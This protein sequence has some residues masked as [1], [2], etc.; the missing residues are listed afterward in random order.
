[1]RA[2]LPGLLILLCCLPGRAPG[3]EFGLGAYGSGI[4]HSLSGDLP[5]DDKWAGG[6]SLGAGLQLELHFTEDIALSFQ[7]G[8]TPRNCQRSFVYQGEVIDRTDYELDY[9]SFPLLVRVSSDP[10][11][12]RG[13]VTAGMNLGHLV[14]GRAKAG[15][16]TSQEI[17]TPL[18]D[19]TIGALFGAG[20]MFPVSDRNSIL[21]ELRYEQG[22][23]D[24]V[25][26]GAATPYSGFDSPSIKY[27][28]F[29]LQASWLF[30]TGGE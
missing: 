1:V 19:Y 5:K 26:R 18:N 6:G 21:V 20:A 17:Q 27:R 10:G 9:L 3:L 7:P 28:V 30:T 4:S 12:I 11:G 8:F 15:D 22:L 13:F 25:D 14:D 2:L 16:G 24:I 29:L 23:E